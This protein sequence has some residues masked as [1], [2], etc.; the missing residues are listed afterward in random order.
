M[1]RSSALIASLAVGLA[2]IAGV[3]AL[4]RTLTLGAR[5][6][7]ATDRTVAQRTAQ[8]D[9]YQASLQKALSRR[10]P[11]LAPV[12]GAP[13]A[14]STAAAP[15]RVIYHRPPPVVVI[16]RASGEHEGEQEGVEWDD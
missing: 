2:A 7:A 15:V 10:P 1:N 6:G 14:G 9:R 12:S 16:Q 3:F 4:G 11:V 13:A 8:L 5:A